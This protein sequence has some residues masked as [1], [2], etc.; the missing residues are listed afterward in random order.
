MNS[1]GQTPVIINFHNEI[2]YLVLFICN[3]DDTWERLGDTKNN[4]NNNNNKKQPRK[5]QN[6]L[7]FKKEAILIT[8]EKGSLLTE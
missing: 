4:N 7:S 3:S 1:I 6:L 8:N 2:N 5:T